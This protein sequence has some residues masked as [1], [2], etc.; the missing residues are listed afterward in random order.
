MRPRSISRHTLALFA[1][2]VTAGTTVI[3][4]QIAQST[5][6]PLTQPLL[7][8]VSS[9]TNDSLA[10]S[11][12]DAPSSPLADAAEGQAG[13]P[14]LAPSTGP[15]APKYKNIILPMQATQP[16]SAGDKVKF[17]FVQAIQ[18]VNIAAWLISSAY[19][20]AVDSAP[21]YGQGWGPYGQRYGAA[22]ARGTMQTLA[23]DSVFAPI[24][25]EDPR[26][27]ELGRQ[28]KL[29]NRAIYAATRTV[30]TRSDSGKQT[31]NFA[32]L[33]GYLVTAGATNAF[34]PERDRTTSQ[35]FE[36]FGGSVGGAALG[37]LF[38]EFVDD[39]L[40]IVHLRK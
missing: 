7:A 15:I 20:Q 2:A 24:F 6:P 29:V 39:G 13:V 23:T 11:L 22:A 17:G 9:S 21:H 3:S 30:L 14:S 31:V 25:H 12:P 26:Y 32:L 33:S 40:R 38:N 35:T 1:V 5:L 4:A 18:P 19:S 16:L 36:S 27:Y 8:A 34:Y 28:H 10:L 37:F